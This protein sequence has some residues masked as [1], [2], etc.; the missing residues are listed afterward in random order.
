LQRLWK[1]ADPPEEKP[2]P[3]KAGAASKKSNAAKETAPS[4]ASSASKSSKG[5][6]KSS[7]QTAAAGG[8]GKADKQVLLE[9]TPGMDTLESRR[10]ARLIIGGIGLACAILLGWITYRGLFAPRAPVAAPADD[11]IL[12]LAKPPPGLSPDQEAHFMFNRAH[13]F[14]KNGRTDQAIA[15]LNR[16]IKV[17]KGTAA[18]GEAQAAL[19]RPKKNLPLFSDRPLVVAEAETPAPAPTPDP[20]PVVI[21]AAPAQPQPGEGRAALVL[22]ANPAETATT[23]PSTQP[24]PAI[25]TRPLPPG[26]QPSL[27]A[28][29]HA[30]GWPT[31][32]VGDRDGGPMVLVPGGTFTMGAND[33]P[34][35]ERPAHQVRLSSYY[36]DQHEVTNRQFRLF[37]AES[38]Y[39]G[40]PAGKWLSDEKM[41]T[42]PE[43]LPAVQV[44]FRDAEAFA[45]WAGKR[46][47]TE[48]QW[49]M[50]ARSSD[51]RRY[52]WG[53]E[54][55]KWSRPRTPRQPEPIMSFPEDRSPFGV[56]DMA[57][58]VHEWTSDWFDSKYY[59]LIAKQAI[60]NPAGP[61]PASRSPQRVV[62]GA[63]KNGSLSYREGV[64]PDRRIPFLGFRCV[65]NV[66]GG[67]PAP[68]AAPAVPG[69]APTPPRNPGAVPF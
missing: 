8:P 27:Q 45:A 6:S 69:A 33:G 59:S 46:L 1:E 32:I 64:P 29:V 14:A 67:T 52:P 35:S 16:V 18:A 22:P 47:P 5:K 7:K 15:M 38:H 41:R 43:N 25:A 24:Q 19:D 12:A 65:L 30:S 60:D 53:D 48:A 44:N 34:A 9:A 54:P 10:R 17:Y 20:P 58:N 42:E 39:R 50:A 56:F 26:F 36:I 11:P 3:A 4:Q 57:G 61:N 62:R 40:E 63:D 31:V 23:A 49:E 51:G 37:L 28:G 55:A 21:A 68:A 66:E 13:E 2:E